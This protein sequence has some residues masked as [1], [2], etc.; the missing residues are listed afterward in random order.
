MPKKA[1]KKSVPK[2]PTNSNKKPNNE[3]NVDGFIIIAQIGF[4]D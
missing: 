4:Y 1:E 3:S 2:R